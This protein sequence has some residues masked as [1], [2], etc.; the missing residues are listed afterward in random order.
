MDP[1]DSC[2]EITSNVTDKIGIIMHTNYDNC[3]LANQVYNV[4][5]REGNDV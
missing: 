1:F 4:L 3:S 5:A 2:G